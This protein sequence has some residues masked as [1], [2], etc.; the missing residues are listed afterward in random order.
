M[1]NEA[2]TGIYSFILSYI[3]LKLLVSGFCFI[4][5]FG[6]FVYLS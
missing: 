4:L 3:P 6:L 2:F 5:L 1:G